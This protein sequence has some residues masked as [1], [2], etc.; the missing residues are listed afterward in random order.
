MIRM[1][2]FIAVHNGLRVMMADVTCAYLQAMTKE[3]V[4]T[5]AGIEWGEELAGCIL[6]LL[7]SIYGL[8]TSGARWYER[9]DEILLSLGFKPCHAG[10][11]IWIRMNKDTYDFIAIYV[12]DLFV[13]SLD[14]E[15]IISAIRVMF[16][17]KGEGFPEYY[18]GGNIDRVCADFT[19]SGET[20]TVSARTFIVGLARR[21]E[22]LMG[23]FRH[24]S[25]PMDP[26]YKPE[27][28]ETSL[29]VGDEIGRY[30]MLVGSLQWAVTL[31]RFDVAYATNTLA[32]YTSMPREGHLKAAHRV[33][34]YLKHFSKG[35]VL[36]DTRPL[37][38]PET[39]IVPN[40]SDWFQQYP[41]AEE[42]LP[43]DTPPAI[44]KP[45][46]MTTF[47]DA[48]HASCVA[49]RRS[50]TGII[51]FFESTPVMFHVGRQKT[52]ETSSYGS[53]AVSARIATEQIIAIRYRLR[54]LGVPVNTHSVLLGDNR[55]VQISGSQ[56]S[57]Q[58]QKK[59]LAV[60]FHKIREAVAARIILFSWIGTSFNVADVL[61]KPLNGQ[62]YRSLISYILFGKG[63]SFVEGSN[64][65]KEV[66]S[67]DLS[68]E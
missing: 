7:K 56:P 46:T 11:S 61:T 43:D 6:L 5:I 68:L 37:E 38:L 31:C 35:R 16:S 50:V 8:R 17:L 54:M 27:I 52:V 63:K 30:R 10:V 24:H 1:L 15:S 59:H 51:H 44:F 19:D 47:V 66:S 58:L 36:F 4:Y 41:D 53:E 14:P 48:D 32:R 28:D 34:G 62:K 22:E 42:C 29:L 65:N 25:T 40:L 3:K 18:L 13:V 20:F 39:I 60:A 23:P 2:L 67:L 49:T 9:L 21:V 57:S 12:D 64:S 55:S 33:V 45:I 26:S